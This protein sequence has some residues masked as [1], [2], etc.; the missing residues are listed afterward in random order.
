VSASGSAT[1]SASL[2]TVISLSGSSAGS[3]STYAALSTKIELVGSAAGASITAGSLATA[4]T[5]AGSAAGSS[6][7][8]ADLSAGAGWDGSLGLVYGIG[9]SFAFARLT[10][11]LAKRTKAIFIPVPHRMP[12]VAQSLYENLVLQYGDEEG[13]NVW[14]RMLLERKGP[15]AEGAKYDPD[16]PEV[17]AQL[18]AAGLH[19]DGGLASRPLVAHDESAS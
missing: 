9:S 4:I 15:F 16:D 13:A 3:S 6:T 8:Y 2:T 7:T 18:M 17:A 10:V 12:P 11:P 14:A 1:A 19:P 5:L